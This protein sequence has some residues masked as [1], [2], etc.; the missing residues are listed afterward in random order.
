LALLPAVEYDGDEVI[1][2]MP[3]GRKIVHQRFAGRFEVSGKAS[4]TSQQVI[5]IDDQMRRHTSG[6]RGHE[7]TVNPN[8]AWPTGVIL[9]KAA[10][11]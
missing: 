10:D 7:Q 4:G 3:I 1:L 8:S 5:P 9:D 6:Y 11:I 2:S